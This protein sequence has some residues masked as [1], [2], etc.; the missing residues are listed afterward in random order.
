MKNTAKTDHVL[1]DENVKLLFFE[2]ID[3]LYQKE[4]FGFLDEV[5]EYVSQIEQYFK[6]EIPK[7]HRLGLTKKAMPYFKK[8]GENLFFVAY[9]RTKTRTTWYAFFEI[10]N[11]RYFK[12]VH[13]INNHTKE[14]AYIEHTL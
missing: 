6:T 5:K 14:A 2:L 7:L 1:F 13:I 4:Y 9:R 11:G 8:Y 10:F 12:V 3:I